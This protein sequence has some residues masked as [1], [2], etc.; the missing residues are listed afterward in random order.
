MLSVTMLIIMFRLQL[1]CISYV[2]CCY[3]VCHYAQCRYAKC[4]GAEKPITNTWKGATTL[5][6]T[7]FTLTTLKIMTFSINM[8]LSLM[9]EHCYAQGHLFSMSLMLSVT[10]K[11]FMMSVI[12]LDV[13]AP[14]KI[15]KRKQEKTIT[16]V[17]PFLRWIYTVK[18]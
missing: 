1:W 5:S 7:T 9:A 6:I 15:N 11:P 14:L 17:V 13:V 3:S 16:V 8:T 12:M 10:H 4:H 2:K 18:L